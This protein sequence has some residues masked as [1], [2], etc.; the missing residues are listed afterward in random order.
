[1]AREPR[2]VRRLIAKGLV[3]LFTNTPDGMRRTKYLQPV[4]P[5]RPYYVFLCLPQPHFVSYEDYRKVRGSLLE[6]CCMVVKY[7]FPEALDIVGIAS[8]PVRPNSG[9]SEDLLY[10]NARVW[11]DKLN[12]EAAKLQNDLGILTSGTFFHV[13]ENEY[14]DPQIEKI[15]GFTQMPKVGRNDPCPCGSGKKYKHCHGR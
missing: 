15:F 8:E 10:L 13:H 2:T 6:A 5:G 12:E 1:M 3:D 11:S 7:K 4:S 14:P 9:S